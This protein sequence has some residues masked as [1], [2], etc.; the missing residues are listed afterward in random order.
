MHKAP[1]GLGVMGY[2][3]MWFCGGF[4]MYR[5]LRCFC[6]IKLRI[7][8]NRCLDYAA[9]ALVLKW[10]MLYSGCQFLCLIRKSP[11]VSSSPYVCVCVCVHVCVCLYLCVC[12]CVR[13]CVY[14]Y[15][16]ACV[17]LCLCECVSLPVCEWRRICVCTYVHTLCVCIYT[18]ICVYVWVYVFLHAG[19]VPLCVCVAHTCTYL[20]CV[21]QL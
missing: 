20:M 10:F 19:S 21:M 17:C 6:W 8:F 16:C 1:H 9:I 11:R 13:A 4:Y 15:V 2:I 14:A 12:V 7:E 5:L 18:Y 3:L